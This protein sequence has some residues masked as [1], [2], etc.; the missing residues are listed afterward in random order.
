MTT[1]E[2]TH[3]ATAR[4][5]AVEK[6]G[7]TA[8]DASQV[9]LRARAARARQELASTLDAIEY[10]LNVPRQVRLQ[11]RRITA[12]LRKLGDDNP[13]ALAGVALG[14]A[15]AVGAA[16]WA[17]VMALERRTVQRRSVQTHAGRRR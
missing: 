9:E 11:T 12:S 14:A 4:T 5:T 15:A 10:K 7:P 16:V 13:L 1:D 6:A 3:G 8:S 17:G 2:A